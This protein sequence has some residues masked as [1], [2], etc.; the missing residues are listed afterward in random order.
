MSLPLA[1]LSAADGERICRAI[2]PALPEGTVAEIIERGAGTP[3]LVEELASLASRPGHLLLVPD[4]VQATVRE[5]AGCL[6]PGG[7]ALLEAAAVAGLEV[8]ADL[9]ASVLP[10]G[11]P[12]DL[13]SAACSNERRSGSGSAIRC[14]RRRPTRRYRP[15]VDVCCTSRSRRLWREVAATPP[16]ESPLTSSGLGRPEAALSVLETAAGEA[17]RAGQLGR[18][19]TL[20]LGAFQLAG[21]HGTLAGQRARLEDAAIRDLFSVGRWSELDPLVRSAWSRRR[22]LPQAER[23]QLAAVFSAHLF[24]T[25]SIDQAFRVAEDELAALEDSG[26][27][28]V[29]GPLLREA[30]L[31]AWIKGDGAAA[32]AFSDRA[33]DV[34]QRTSDVDLDIRARRIE[35]MIAYG[36]RREP[37][38]AIRRL[39]EN[40]ASA[41]AQGLAVNEAFALFYLSHITGTSYYAESARQLSQRAGAWFWLFALRDAT[42]QLLEGRREV[43]EAIFGHVHHEVR[44]GIPTMAALVDAKEACLYLHRGDLDEARKLLQ[45]PSAASDA[46]SCGVIGAER[47]AACGWLAWEEG[48]LQEACTH[49]ASAGADNVMETYN[50]VS[51]GPAFLALRVDALVRLGQAEEAAAAISGFEA[52]NLG[53]ERFMAAALAAARF[54]LE[55]TLERALTAETVTAAA[56]WPWLHALV[57]CWRGEFLQDAGAAED[58]RN[59]SRRSAPSLGS[60]GPRRCCGSSGAAATP[61]TRRCR[62]FPARDRGGGTGR[63]GP[64]Q[65]GHR[66]APVP[67]P[68]DRG[69]PRGAH[70]DQARFLL[71]GA[72]RR[73]GRTAPHTRALT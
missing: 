4:I 62:P 26:S 65:S 16:S 69:Q 40:A 1:R 59:S 38:A 50:T 13:V 23:A 29:G 31:I 61:R 6:D 3:L 46:S 63:R 25:G 68:T 47:S 14:C 54:R 41:R 39:Q 70:L 36:E 58:A 28:D 64:V 37:Q 43:S 21:R 52:F 55:P 57:G 60:A 44:L 42:I 66:P 2:D 53:H 9:M 71:Q 49:L 67:E 30:A 12:G 24:W 51:G 17:N 34:A 5:R 15:S 22:A 45:G 27:P 20:H 35:T 73:M 32:R 7:R 48:R 19:A 18:A 8:D 56:P 11:R 72:D 10:E 33:L